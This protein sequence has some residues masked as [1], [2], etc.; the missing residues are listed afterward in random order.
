M[1]AFGLL[2]S[3]RVTSLSNIRF[4][5]CFPVPS[6]HF[7]LVPALLPEDR[8]NI[9]LYN[10]NEAPFFGRIYT[11][12]Y[13]PFGL[14]S[15]LMVR[16][17]LWAKSLAYWRH[18]LVFEFRSCKG[19]L[20]LRQEEKQ[21]HIGVA[22]GTDGAETLRLLTELLELFSKSWFS[23]RTRVEVT[24]PTCHDRDSA[25][26]ATIGLDTI[27]LAALKGFSKH[28]LHLSPIRTLF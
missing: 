7:T 10:L 12:E 6:E 11:L 26:A 25:R 18:G 17:M 24:C 27:E 1:L 13:L 4:D 19:Y 23:V 9:A 22:G 20:Q 21:I 3:T 14:F 16:V 8:P 28:R 5:V 15:R 2:E